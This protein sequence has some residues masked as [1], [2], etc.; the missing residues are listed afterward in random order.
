MGFVGVSERNVLA[1]LSLMDE[2]AYQ[3]V[4]AALRHGHQAMVFVHSRKDTGKTGRTLGLKAQQGGD[5]ALFDC[6]ADE[7]RG[8][9]GLGGAWG[10]GWGRGEGSSQGCYLA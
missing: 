8:G 3:K 9:R 6:T 4:A 7:V 2:I 5:G 10:A 1:R